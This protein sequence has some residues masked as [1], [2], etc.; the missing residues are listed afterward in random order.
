MC[1]RLFLLHYLSGPLHL[2]AFDKFGL[3]FLLK[4]VGVGRCLFLFH[5]RVALVSPPIMD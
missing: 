5:L 2:C 3:G 4:V 1:L